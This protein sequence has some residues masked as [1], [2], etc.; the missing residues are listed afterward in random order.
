M[1]YLIALLLVFSMGLQAQ[2][3]D[4]SKL[5]SEDFLELCQKQLLGNCWVKTSGRMNVRSADGERQPHMTIKC[6]AQLVPNK[7]IFKSTLEGK[8]SFKVENVFGDK[9]DVKVLENT[10]GEDNGFK[11][12]GIKP[13][14]LSLAFMYWDYIKEYEKEKLGVL[15]ISCR[16]L[17]LGNPNSGEF[18]KVWLSE[19]YLGPLK[20]EWYTNLKKDPIQTLTFEDFAE[21]NRVWV[22]L[23]VKI[24][25]AKGELQVKFEKVDAAFST[26]IP[27]G[28]FNTEN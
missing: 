3:T 20:V 15:L 14:D 28:L 5:T 8:Q 17:L 1:K 27:E 23:E 2:V 19:K 13:E 7:I 22:P 12:V 25:N 11:K 26:Q 18:V 21:K 24:S 4:P 10:L 6:A 9:H 16:V